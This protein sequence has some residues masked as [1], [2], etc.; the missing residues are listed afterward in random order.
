[1]DYLT[2]NVLDLAVILFKNYTSAPL[3]ESCIFSAE[4]NYKEE[5]QSPAYSETSGSMLILKEDG[6]ILSVYFLCS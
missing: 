1:L 2:L 5:V 6:A 3:T 4:N